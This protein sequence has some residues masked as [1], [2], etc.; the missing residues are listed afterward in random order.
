MLEKAVT[1]ESAKKKMADLKKRNKTRSKKKA[2]GFL[3]FDNIKPYLSNAKKHPK[4]QIAQLAD[5]VEKVG[6]RQ[7][8]LVNQGGVIVVGHGRWI[9]WQEHKKRLKPV[10]VMDDK[11]NTIHGEAEKIPL[12]KSQ[13][14][15]YRLADNKLNESEWDMKLVVV[16]LKGLSAEMLDLSGFDKDLILEPD[17]KDDVIPENVPSVAKLGHMW[18][19]GRHR[20]LC[21]DSTKIKDVERLMDGKKADMVFTD[22]PYALFGNSTGVAGITDDKMTRPFF[23]SIFNNAR[24]VLKLFG[25]MYTCCDW[26][27]AF[28]LQAMAKDANLTEKNLCIWDKGD[29]GIGGM[30]QQCYEMIWF[31]AN[32]PLA[33]TTVGKKKT[34]ERTVNGRPNIWRHKREDNTL[35]NAAK[36]VDMI[37]NAI[38]ASSDSGES[39]LDLFLG[40]G[41]TLIAAEKTDRI[42]Y[43]MELDPKYCDV[44]IKRYE[45]YSGN[46]AKKIK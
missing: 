30:Y 34:G 10:W 24:L 15:A 45:E 33:T 29:G 11:G 13:E 23:L 6:W 16:E 41:S 42:C 36:P 2:S 17:E 26:H 22:P 9:T 46:K 8:V 38:K 27:S 25:H 18:A 43:G 12:T 3:L 31:H 14:K 19:L 5:I 39:V 21:G 4:K 7:P 37:I 20:L 1:K 44:I 40:S 28:S 35:H 32:S